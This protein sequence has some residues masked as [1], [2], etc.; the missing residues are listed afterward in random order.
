MIFKHVPWMLHIIK[1]RLDV[2]CC[3]TLA[4]RST[5]RNKKCVLVVLQDS[6]YWASDWYSECSKTQVWQ[7]S[8]QWSS[9]IWITIPSGALL[10]TPIW[11]TRGYGG[12][13]LSPST[14]SQTL[15]SLCPWSRACQSWDCLKKCR[16]LYVFLADHLW[17]CTARHAIDGNMPFTGR[18]FTSAEC[19]ALT[20]SCRQSFYQE[21]SRL[22][23]ELSCW[24]LLLAFKEPQ[25]KSMWYFG[26]LD[27]WEK[28][29]TKKNERL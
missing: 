7:A 23:W 2:F 25:C 3:R 29:F 18:T 1:I 12:S 14:C 13:A 24:T 11:M 8:S 22:S 4:L 9:V 28:V 21:G 15:R 6:H 27:S 26:R 19:A 17:C 16:W 20:G 5:L 10:L